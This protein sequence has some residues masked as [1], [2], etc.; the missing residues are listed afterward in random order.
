MTAN[1]TDGPQEISGLKLRPFTLGTLDLCRELGLTIFS[2]G[3][4]PLDSV[5]RMR[6]IAVY[7]FIQSEP[8]DA[9][10]KAVEEPEFEKNHLRLFKFRLTPGAVEA[11]WSLI[12]RNLSHAGAAVVDIE[13]RPGAKGDDPP[14]NS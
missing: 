7:L 2:E 6:Q 14:P 12:E 1:L 13:P 10:L 3:K 4:V 9:V 8:L 11:A 5:E